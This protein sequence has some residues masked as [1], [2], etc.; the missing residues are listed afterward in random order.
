MLQLDLTNP[1]PPAV[2]CAFTAARNDTW[3]GQGQGLE[4]KDEKGLL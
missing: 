1:C 3:R 4:T 2:E